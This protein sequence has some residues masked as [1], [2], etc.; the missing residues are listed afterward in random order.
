MS[1]AI[2]PSRGQEM[3]LLDRI[4]RLA[5]APQ[6]R[7]A[8][9]A[10]FSRLRSRPRI[11]RQLV[12]ARSHL[13]RGAAEL[14]AEVFAMASG[15]MVLLMRADRRDRIEDLARQVC[16][17]FPSDPCAHVG[18]EGL[19]E[20][21]DLEADLPRLRQ[22]AQ[23][24]EAAARASARRRAL[25]IEAG[26][27][28]PMT[29]AILSQVCEA[30]DRSDVSFLVRRQPVALWLEG[31]PPQPIFWEIY[32]SIADL[33]KAVAPETDL[34]SDRWLFQH[35]TSALDRR[36]LAMLP[37]AD[38]RSLMAKVSLNLNISTVLSSVFLD[39]DRQLRMTARGTICIELQALDVLAD[40]R[41]FAIA[42]TLLHSR[43]YKICIDNL[44]PLNAPMASRRAL[45][46]DLAKVAFGE[47]LEPGAEG[48]HAE[49]LAAWIAE[50]GP[51]RV[52]LSRVETPEMVAVGRRI[53]MNL[54]QG[55]YVDMELGAARLRAG[56]R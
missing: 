51:E 18:P 26:G 34:A 46:F 40:M 21:M 35:L 54:F 17:T 39:F 41:G 50:T 5:R 53:G 4:D 27:L 2:A 16:E 14:E 9:V 11:Q 43:G 28:R 29:P 23:A 42:R 56:A 45:G 15:D 33:G 25:G 19:V 36:V 49:R 24:W 55:R 30:I 6:G 38:D 20:L 12:V 8:L 31:A 37:R 32:A 1:H 7:Q 10:V 3:A 48:V 22:M 13:E 47:E 44:D 52:I